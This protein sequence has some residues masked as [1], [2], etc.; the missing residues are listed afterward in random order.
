MIC[1]VKFYRNI[2]CINKYIFHI[3]NDGG[4]SQK[5]L[6]GQCCNQLEVEVHEKVHILLA[7]AP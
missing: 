5:L 1:V 2:I 7:S 6:I 4:P 3:D